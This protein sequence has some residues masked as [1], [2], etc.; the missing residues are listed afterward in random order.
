MSVQKQKDFMISSLIFSLCILGWPWPWH[1]DL[2]FSNVWPWRWSVDLGLDW[3]VL[4]DISGTID[5]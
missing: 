2:D 1:C 3:S 5:S 4:V